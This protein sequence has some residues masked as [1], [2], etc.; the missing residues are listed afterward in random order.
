MEIW[1]ILTFI[2]TALM[3]LSIGAND[4]DNGLATCYGFNALSLRYLLILGA[5]LEFLGAMFCSASVAGILS[6]STFPN[7]E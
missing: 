4:A 7:I 1:F 2:F 5:C 3:A 6:V